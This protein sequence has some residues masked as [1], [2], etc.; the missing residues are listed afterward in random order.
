MDK[1]FCDPNKVDLVAIAGE[2][3]YDETPLQQMVPQGNIIDIDI[4]L[5]LTMTFGH[6]TV[7]HFILGGQIDIKY[8]KDQSLA[9]CTRQY[10]QEI[11]CFSFDHIDL[12]KFIILI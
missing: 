8:S 1:Q 9:Q 2:I 4:D 6:I 11:S 12:I 5:K 10:F 3:I 7:P